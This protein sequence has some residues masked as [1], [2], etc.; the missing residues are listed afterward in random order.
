MELYLEILMKIFARDIKQWKKVN[1]FIKNLKN[2]EIQFL[3]LIQRLFF[4][5]S[6]I[7]TLAFLVPI[8]CFPQWQ[9][10]IEY[11]W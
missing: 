6:D 1:A 4:P 9:S 8:T 7:S 11:P 3:K 5:S 2:I 10:S